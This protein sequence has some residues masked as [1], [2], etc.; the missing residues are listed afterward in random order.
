MEIKRSNQVGS[1]YQ[2][3]A[4]QWE[5]CLFVTDIDQL[6]QSCGHCVESARM[7]ANVMSPEELLT[8][9]KKEVG[10]DEARVQVLLLLL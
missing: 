1:S 4:G 10:E 8:E 9:A 7:V 3:L 5:F 6:D 2:L